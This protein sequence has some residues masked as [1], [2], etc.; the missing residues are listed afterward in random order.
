MNIVGR[1]EARLAEL[2]SDLFGL[3]AGALP[4]LII[5]RMIGKP[6][7]FPAIKPPSTVEDVARTPAARTLKAQTQTAEICQRI[8]VRDMLD[9]V[10][11]VAGKPELRMIVKGVEADA[12]GRFTSGIPGQETSGTRSEK[13]PLSEHFHLYTVPGFAA[14][15]AAIVASA[16]PASHSD[17]LE[18]FSKSIG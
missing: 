18:I 4:P 6:P 10:L 17:S 7:A 15:C 11:A 16:I 12:A 8:M 9:D 14:S 5:L 1:D 2:R 3:A 13:A